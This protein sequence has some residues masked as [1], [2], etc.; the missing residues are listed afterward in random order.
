MYTDAEIH[1]ESKHTCTYN[2]KIDT[3]ITVIECKS[4]KP[5]NRTKEVDELKKK[6][7]AKLLVL[8][9]RRTP[10]DHFAHEFHN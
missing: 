1:L 9:R 6:K 5:I 4:L 8:R 10:K 3:V 2:A 7:D